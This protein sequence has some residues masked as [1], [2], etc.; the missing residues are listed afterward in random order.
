VL[1]QAA[2]H[3]PCIKHTVGNDVWR[4][5]RP[6]CFSPTY[7]S[8]TSTLQSTTLVVVP[9]HDL[10]DTTCRQCDASH[11]Y[12]NMYSVQQPSVLLCICATAYLAAIIGGQ[13][14]RCCASATAALQCFY[15]D[16]PAAGLPS[17]TF[18]DVG[19]QARV[20]AAC[21]QSLLTCFCTHAAPTSA[22]RQ[23][24]LK[25]NKSTTSVESYS[26]KAPAIIV[27]RPD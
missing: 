8:E 2:R 13:M 22:C 1:L 17:L 25:H 12:S 14:Q 24:Q 15:A 27:F 18:H 7:K 19:K 23:N 10:L 9:G 6:T 5:S 20:I 11:A 4:C 3:T 26:T 21:L 16:A